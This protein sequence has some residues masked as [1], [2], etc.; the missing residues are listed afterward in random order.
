MKTITLT[1]LRDIL[2]KVN[3]AMP[4]AFSSITA[5]KV[6]ANPYG[7]ILKLSRVSNFI[8]FNY[9]HSV[10]NQM[11]REGIEGTFIPQPRKWGHHVSPVLIEHKGQYYLSVQVLRTRKPV[12]LVKADGMTKVIPSDAVKPFLPVKQEATSQ[13]T[14]KKVIYR[15]YKLE[16]LHQITMNKETYKIAG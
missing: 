11:A 10:E 7:E 3:H 8:G 15:D 13:P 14:E 2:A 1:Q 12:Y 9:R 5:P 6:N 16:S 4:I